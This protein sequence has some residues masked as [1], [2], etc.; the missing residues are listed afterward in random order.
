LA[1][2]G[3]RRAETEELIQ[4][5]AASGGA[6]HRLDFGDGLVL[7]GEYDLSKVLHHYGIPSDLRGQRVL[8]IGTATGFLGFECARRGAEVTAIDIWDGV[9]YERFRRATGLDT[10]YVQKSIYDLDASFGQFDLVVC[11]SLLLHLPDFVGALRCIRSVC[12]GTAII[13]SSY[14]EMPGSEDRGLCDFVGVR[15]RSDAGEYWV[16]WNVSPMA[17]RKM[18][19]AADFSEAVEVSRFDL[20]SEPGHNDFVVPHVVIH[21]TV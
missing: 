4:E 19:L 8:D 10:R 9:L 1:N 16:Y 6:Y 7:D 11:G 2:D 14:F 3:E 21:G 5:V 18:L 12:R 13:T 17:L 15:T 20:V